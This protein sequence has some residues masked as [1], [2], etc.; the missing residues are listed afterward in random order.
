MG[1]QTLKKQVGL[2]FDPRLLNLVDNFAKEKGMNRTEFVE[3][4]VR[5]YIAREINRERKAKEQS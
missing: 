2:R 1:G 5:V 4:A 3:K